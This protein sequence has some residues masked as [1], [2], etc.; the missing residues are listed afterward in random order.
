MSKFHRSLLYRRD[1]APHAQRGA[2]LLVSL[3]FLLL[4]TILALSASSRSLLQERMAGGLRNAQQ[5]Q[6]AANAALRAAEWTIWSRTSQ[7]GKYMDCQNGQISSDDGCVVYN[8]SNASLYGASGTVTNFQTSSGWITTGAHTYTG[9]TG[10]GYTGSNTMTTNY[11]QLAQNPVYIIE[12][13]GLELP[14]GA[15]TQHEAGAT[16]PTG[17]GPGQV[18]THVFRITARAT[19]GSPN[20]VSVLQS[21]FDAQATN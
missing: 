6:M 12:D 17:S 2:A 16:G 11:S 10:Q 8:A 21:T 15:G 19:G 1:A 7:V 20:T 3:I 18:S 14:P 5:A 9:P 4:L 13:M